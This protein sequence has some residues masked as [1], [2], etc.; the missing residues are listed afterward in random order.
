MGLIIEDKLLRDKR[1]V[2]KDRAESGKELLRHLE[3][4]RGKE[5]IVLAIPSGGLPV[6]AEISRGLG[7]V[8]D[9]MIVRKLQIP[10]NPEAGFGA[11]SLSGESIM[12]TELL[13]ELSLSEEQIARSKEKAMKE[14]RSRESTLRGRR[15]MPELAR[16]AVILVDDGLATGYTMLAAIKEVKAKHP[17]RIVVA[18]PTG[19]VRSVDMVARE[20]D[21]IVCPNIREMPFAVADAFRNWYDVDEAEAVRLIQG[22]NQSR[23]L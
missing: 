9:V 11:I 3:A 21:E 10:R 16:K 20:V 22:A 1:F 18:V 14:G 13:T 19:S 23:S 8:L 12:N 2:F 17:G 5:V 15:P 6:A 7:A 4:Y